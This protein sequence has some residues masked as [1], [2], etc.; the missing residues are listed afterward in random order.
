MDLPAEPGNKRPIPNRESVPN[1]DT[2]EPG[3][4][5]NRVSGY[6]GSIDTK[7]DEVQVHNKTARTIGVKYNDVGEQEI[8]AISILKVYLFVHKVERVHR[9][10]VVN[11]SGVLIKWKRRV[12]KA[13][14][15]AIKNGYIN[16]TGTGTIQMSEK[17]KRF[18][19]EY[20]RTFEECRQHYQRQAAERRDRPSYYSRK[21]AAIQA[22]NEIN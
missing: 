17:G 9:V 18:I 6:A 8:E 4:V 22:S 20:Q 14:D 21:K 13:I 12:N 2:E 3:A 1:R 10:K 16:L 7:I 15:Q 19:D 5:Y 11:W